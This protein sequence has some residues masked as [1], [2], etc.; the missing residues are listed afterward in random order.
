LGEDIYLEPIDGGAPEEAPAW[1]VDMLRAAHQPLREHTTRTVDNDDPPVRLYAEGLRWWTGELVTSKLT[2]QPTSDVQGCSVDRSNTLFHIGRAL[3]EA[4]ASHSTIVS[5]LA[6]RDR[7]LGYDKYADRRDEGLTEY[8]RIA[9]KALSSLL[10]PPTG[11]STSSS[12]SRPL[13]PN[14]DDDDRR[15]VLTLGEL[16]ER[17]SGEVRWLV[18]GYIAMSELT[19]IPAPPESFKSWTMADLVRSVLT[20]SKWLGHF[21]VQRGTAIYCEQERANNLVYQINRLEAGAGCDLSG[22]AVIPPCGLDICD[23]TWQARLTRMVEKR[24]PQLVVVNSFRSVFRRNAID[25]VHVAQGLGWLGHL[26]EQSGAAVVMVDG[27]NK[28]GGLGYQRGMSA[29]ADSLQKEYEADCVLHIERNRDAVGLG[30][31]PARLYVG[32]RRAGEKGPPFRFDVEELPS[33]GVRLVYLGETTVERSTEQ[34]ATAADKVL[35]A[36]HNAT[37]PMSPQALAGVTGLDVGTVKNTLTALKAQGLMRN[38][39]RGQWIVSSSSSQ[40]YRGNDDDDEES[41]EAGNRRGCRSP[42]SCPCCV[43]TYCVRPPTPGGAAA[44]RQSGPSSESAAGRP[45]PPVRR[46][47]RPCTAWGTINGYQRRISRY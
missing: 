22:L 19:L 34:P 18:P 44:P 33:G 43:Y 36:A 17:Y 15:W 32:K 13:Y 38:V 3:A 45:G 31:G 46:L 30:V 37:S 42:P 5:A 16:R 23:P 9:S 35:A 2:Q 6:N 27:T 25:G 11:P 41:A 24:Q 39:D 47:Q 10:D 4:R 29:H 21:A 28:P 8:E 26:A 14:D 7:N 40:D 12:S 1:A 20:G